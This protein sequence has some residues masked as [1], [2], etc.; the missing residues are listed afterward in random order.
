MAG[1]KVVPLFS[2]R[3]KAPKVTTREQVRDHLF[4][5]HDHLAS[6]GMKLND[7]HDTHDALHEMVANHSHEG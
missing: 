7:L 6:S 5:S 1:G 2:D 3:R 4:S